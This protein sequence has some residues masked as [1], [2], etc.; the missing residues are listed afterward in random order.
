MHPAV[1]AGVDV[2][3]EP[4]RVLDAVEGVEEEGK[5]QGGCVHEVVGYVR[6]E[7]GDG[8]TVRA[9]EERQGLGSAGRDLGCV[10]L[11]GGEVGG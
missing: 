1:D 8:K 10:H 5:W 7:V 11:V 6:L 9:V 3:A 4:P 2:A